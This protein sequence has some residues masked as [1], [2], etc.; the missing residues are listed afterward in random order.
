M[1]LYTLFFAHSTNETFFYCFTQVGVT[2]EN[3]IHNK[4][5]WE[6]IEDVNVRM[7]N[8]SDFLTDICPEVS[9]EVVPISDIFGP[10]ITDPTMEMIIVSKETIRGGE[11]IN[12]SKLKLHQ[13]RFYFL[14][15]TLF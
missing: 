6:L 11:K 4:I 3:M 12:E 1:S 10:S 13:Q 8:V 15:V 2:E 14:H 5:L 9:C 7:K